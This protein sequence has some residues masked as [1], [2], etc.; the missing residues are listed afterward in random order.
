MVQNGRPA[1]ARTDPQPPFTI[2][3]QSADLLTVQFRRVPGIEHSEGES[4]EPGQS[5]FGSQPT[6]NHPVSARLRVPSFAVVRNPIA[7]SIGRIAGMDDQDREP[8]R[9]TPSPGPNT[10]RPV[11]S[12]KTAES[13][14]PAA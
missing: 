13:H 7:I 3:Q 4:V 2:G 5:L 14:K 9:G 6:E 11:W 1:A 8:P 10:P 12:G